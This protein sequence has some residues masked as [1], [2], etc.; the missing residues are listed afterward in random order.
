MSSIHRN[1]VF[2]NRPFFLIFCILFLF[3]IVLL[4]SFIIQNVSE[5]EC[6]EEKKNVF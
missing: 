5:E 2:S 4:V 3:S 1:Q 6:I